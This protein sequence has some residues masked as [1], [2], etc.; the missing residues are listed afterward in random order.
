MCMKKR[1]RE[2]LRE[3]EGERI[4]NVHAFE[5]KWIGM[6]AIGRYKRLR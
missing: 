1:K 2:R 6:E 5:I 3:L 4:R